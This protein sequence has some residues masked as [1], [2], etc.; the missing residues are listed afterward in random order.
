MEK[1]TLILYKHCLRFS[2]SHTNLDPNFMNICPGPT[3][4]Q[5]MLP[6]IVYIGKKEGI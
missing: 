5:C 6:I 4:K 3:N 2:K 1:T